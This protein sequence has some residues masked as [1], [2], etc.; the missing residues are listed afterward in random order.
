MSNSAADL[1]DTVKDGSV[2]DYS[3][4][5]SVP[6]FFA[7]HS[8]PDN[9]QV[10]RDRVQEFMAKLPTH[11]KIVCV[12]S[13]GTTVPLERNTVRF[14][15]NFSTGTRGAAS[16]ERFLAAGYYVVFLTRRGSVQPF[17][18]HFNIANDPDNFLDCLHASKSASDAL[19]F[20][21][22]PEK[23]RL[24]HKVM[25]ARAKARTE[26]RFLRL[27]FTSVEEYIYMLRMISEVL[28]GAGPRAMLYVLFIVVGDVGDVLTVMK[29][30]G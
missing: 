28:S 22:P 26:G 29:K 24:L 14:I 20:Q 30:M 8:P 23:V 13:G 2:D 9:L 12:T 6:E 16:A 10:C 3:T 21:P 11:R 27:P 17:L 7:T 18:R 5:T 25:S 19:T 1:P 15:D 4:S